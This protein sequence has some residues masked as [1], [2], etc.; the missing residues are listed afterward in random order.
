LTSWGFR[1]FGFH[2]RVAE[3]F[4]PA[5]LCL[6]LWRRWDSHIVSKGRAPIIQWGGRHISY[7]RKIYPH[8]FYC[9]D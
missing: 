2:G 7:E 4:S 3:V 9:E 6:D 5:I 8:R 1:V